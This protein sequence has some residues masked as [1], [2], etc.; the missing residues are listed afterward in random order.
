MQKW[1][2][3]GVNSLLLSNLKCTVAIY[4]IR[5]RPVGCPFNSLLVR[6]ETFNLYAPI[7]NCHGIVSIEDT[8]SISFLISI[9]L[10]YHG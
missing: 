7:V 10:K 1:V 3:F 9:T 8:C 4:Q 5:F 2:C 6:L